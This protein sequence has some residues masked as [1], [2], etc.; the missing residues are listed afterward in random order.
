MTMNKQKEMAQDVKELFYLVDNAH[1]FRGSDIFPIALNFYEGKYQMHN[2]C[3]YDRQYDWSAKKNKM[4]MVYFEDEDFHLLQTTPGKIFIQQF[5]S[6]DIQY[7]CNSL[8][9]AFGHSRNYYIDKFV[10]F[11]KRNLVD[12][13]LENWTVIE[14]DNNIRIKV[15]EGYN[16]YIFLEKKDNENYSKLT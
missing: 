4:M 1:N 10:A 5:N 15:G 9:L 3:I 16:Q 8:S 2:I 14:T 13:Q 11:L 7:F 12:H 6:Y